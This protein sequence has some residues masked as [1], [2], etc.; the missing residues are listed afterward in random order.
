MKHKTDRGQTTGFH[1]GL[2]WLV[3][4]LLMVIIAVERIEPTTTAQLAF[5]GVVALVT[6]GG[7][8]G[9]IVGLSNRYTDTETVSHD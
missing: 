5:V 7:I 8:F 2:I 6:T 3:M 9:L 1:P 4:S